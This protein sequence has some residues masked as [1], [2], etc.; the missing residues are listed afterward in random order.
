M[1]LSFLLFLNGYLI[2]EIEKI[3]PVFLY[4]YRKTCGSLG[5]TRNCVETLALRARVPTQ[6]LASTKLPRVFLFNN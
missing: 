6:F 3:F 1:N 5:E 4:S 2:K